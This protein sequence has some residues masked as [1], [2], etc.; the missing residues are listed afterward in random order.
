MQAGVNGVR[1]AGA[2]SQLVLVEGLAVDALDLLP[3][4]ILTLYL[5]RVGPGHGL[6]PVR[7]TLPLSLR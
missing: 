2:T 1:A 6:G 7:A 3:S 4:F 5:E